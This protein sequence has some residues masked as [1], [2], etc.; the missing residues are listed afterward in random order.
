MKHFLTHIGNKDIPEVKTGDFK[1]IS[2]KNEDSLVSFFSQ[3]EVTGQC[4][5]TNIFQKIEK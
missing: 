2:F 5:K 1:N 4:I 3:F